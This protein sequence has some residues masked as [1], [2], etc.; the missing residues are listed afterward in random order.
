MPAPV[1][2]LSE[3]LEAGWRAHC[4]ERTLRELLAS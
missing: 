4:G 2:E 1:A 3:D